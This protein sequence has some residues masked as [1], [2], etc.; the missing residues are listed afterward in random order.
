MNKRAVLSVADKAGLAE[1]AQGLAE[2]GFELVASG[3]TAAALA[4]AGVPATPVEEVAGHGTLLGGRIKTL[5]P[6]LLGGVLADR[7]DPAQLRDLETLG[8]RP[9]E[10][11]VVN[12]YPFAAGVAAGKSA[13]QLT[14]LID[15][16]GPTLVRSAA[17]NHRHVAVVV[18]PADY[19]ELL[20]AL[21]GGGFTAELRARLAAKAFAYTSEYE[22]AISASFGGGEELRYGENPHQKA[23]VVGLDR[24]FRQVHG[25]PVSYNNI[26]D[27]LGAWRCVNEFDEPAAAV[28]KHAT[29]CGVG[30]GDDAAAAMARAQQADP[31]AAYGGVLA[32]N[33]QVDAGRLASFLKGKFFEVVVLPEGEFAAA[34]LKGGTRI[35]LGKEPDR[36]ARDRVTR[37]GVTLV[38]DVDARAVTAAE[39]TVAGKV[40]PNEE[41]IAELLF[42]WRIAKHAQSN[43]VVLSRGRQ[44]IGIGAGQTSRVGSAELAV[45]LAKE[46]GHD[47]AGSCAASDGFFPF[48][49]G[50][51]RLATAGVAAVIQPGGS[52]RDAEVIAAA[53]AAGVALVHAG[54]RHFRH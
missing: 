34:E 30:G 11:V 45:K 41:Q 26:N 7:D 44:S 32:V 8:A 13:E 40:A 20:R 48:A 52:K 24:L 4:E 12:F 37:S 31:V 35:L 23:E 39:L 50:L 51:E 16:G 43:A 19:G 2:R 25:K 33:R 6:A 22:A 1:L 27:A 36:G 5:H 21:D 9:V 14:E 18:D 54:V 42:A 3:G 17:K 29:P 46:L 47:P 53:D 15:I 49:D 28:I 10:L 38:Q